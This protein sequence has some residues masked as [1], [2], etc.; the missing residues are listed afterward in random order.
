MWRYI[1]KRI[2]Y[3][4]PTVLG[5]CLLA[6]II[7]RLIPGV[8]GKKDSLKEESFSQ[9]LLEYPQYTKPENFKGQKVPKVL[10]SGNHKKITLW[11]KEQAL[12]KTLKN[13]PDLLK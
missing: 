7:V 2:G 8:V 5:A 12:K 11:R 10:I 1:L 6:F 4:I 13:R 9:K 3:F